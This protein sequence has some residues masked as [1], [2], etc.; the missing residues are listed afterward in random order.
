M[1]HDPQRLQEV[2]EE[3]SEWPLEKRRDFLEN[4]D[5]A[6]GRQSVDQLKDALR[7]NWDKR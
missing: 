5:A 2:V 4:I 1:I 3:V 6:F 7:A